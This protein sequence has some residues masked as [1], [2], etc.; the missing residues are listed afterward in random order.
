MPIRQLHLGLLAF[1]T[2]HFGGQALTVART[3]PLDLANRAAG[4]NGAHLLGLACF[5]VAAMFLLSLLVQMFGIAEEQADAE[6]YAGLGFIGA[7]GLTALG[8]FYGPAPLLGQAIETCMTTATALVA[9][10]IAMNLSVGPA[11]SISPAIDDETVAEL[12]IV[13]QRARQAAM[14]AGLTRLTGKGPAR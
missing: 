2:I 4:L 14:M 6:L 11:R 3:L 12:D 13:S 9:S 7:F 8:V 1:W 10:A 5:A